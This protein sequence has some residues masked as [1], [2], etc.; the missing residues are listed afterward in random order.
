MNVHQCHF[1]N[2]SLEQIVTGVVV[3]ICTLTLGNFP[4]SR[5]VLGYF[6]L[7]CF[8]CGPKQVPS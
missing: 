3:G 7:Q 2:G 6:V 4:D 8:S 1:E 5:S